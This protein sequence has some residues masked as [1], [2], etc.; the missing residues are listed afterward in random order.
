MC[1][2]AAS[3]PWGLAGGLVDRPS[4]ESPSPFL[5]GGWADTVSSAGG[6][7]QGPLSVRLPAAVVVTGAHPHACIRSPSSRSDTVWDV[8]VGKALPPSTVLS[9]L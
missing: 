5:G 8:T 7:D 1:M 6:S 3:R 4:L 2:A 9:F